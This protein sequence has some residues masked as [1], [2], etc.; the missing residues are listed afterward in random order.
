MSEEKESISEIE[1][2]LNDSIKIS[3]GNDAPSQ[4]EYYCVF[5]GKSAYLADRINHRT[6]CENLKLQ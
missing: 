5:C 4:G 6:N 1:S 3:Y 2:K